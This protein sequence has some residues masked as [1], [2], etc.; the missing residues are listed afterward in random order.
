MINRD[1]KHRKVKHLPKAFSLIK[2]DCGRSSS[3]HKRYQLAIRRCSSSTSSFQESKALRF[4]RRYDFKANGI[5]GGAHLTQ[6]GQK[7]EVSTDWNL[8]LDSM[9]G[10]VWPFLVYLI[11]N[12]LNRRIHNNIPVNKFI[13]SSLDGIA[14]LNPMIWFHCGLRNR[15]LLAV[16]DARRYSGPYTCYTQGNEVWMYRTSEQSTLC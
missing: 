10:S 8:F 4:R 12:L 9:G 13:F 7:P 5:D 3:N 15:R 2:N 6:H 16:R 11:P 14:F 1:V